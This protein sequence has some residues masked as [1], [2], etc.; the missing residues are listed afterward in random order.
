MSKKRNA[1]LLQKT[2][3]VFDLPGEAVAGE[4]RVTVT[5]TEK[6][7]VENHRG[8]LEYGDGVILVNARGVMIKIRGQNLSVQAMSDLELVVRGKIEAVEFLE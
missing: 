1:A 8:L 4:P 5:G 7:H 2:A 3:A 6:V